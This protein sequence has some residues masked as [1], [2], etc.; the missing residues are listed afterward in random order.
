MST[1]MLL[2]AALLASLASE[3]IQSDSRFS[4]VLGLTDDRSARMK[5][6]R[7][8]PEYFEQCRLVN[9]WKEHLGHV[10]VLAFLDPSWQYSFRQAVM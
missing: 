3:E 8:Q 1:K 10:S 5:Q 9:M 4:R 7:E 2:I 6:H